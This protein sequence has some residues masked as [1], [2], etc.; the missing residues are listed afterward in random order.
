MGTR[1]RSAWGRGGGARQPGTQIRAAALSHYFEVAGRFG[2]DATALLR[3]VGLTRT[4]LADPSRPIPATAAAQLLELSAAAARCDSF[5]LRMAE[6]RQFSDFGPVSLLLAHQPTLRDALRTVIDY[7]HLLN[8]ALAMELEDL[9]QLAVVREE[10]AL[11]EARA[12][13]QST[14]LVV[15]VVLLIFRAVL[16]PQWR[17]RAVHFTHAAPAELAVHRRLFGCAPQFAADFN[18]LTCVAADL[19][20]PNPQADAEM[21]R[22]ARGFLDALPRRG[23]DALAQDVRRSIY[24]LLPLGRASAEQVASGLGLHVRTLQRRLGAR[25][26]AFADLLDEVRGELARRYIEGTTHSL[27][28]IAGLLGYSNPSA[29]TRW[30]GQRHGRP[31]S[32][33]RRGPALAE[34]EPSDASGAPDGSGVPRPHATPASRAG[35]RF[36]RP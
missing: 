13:R 1:T 21:A 34:H 28:R 23:V 4:L 18:G 22:Y 24:L 25:G 14:E 3:Q 31:P 33:L 16:G 5:G 6:A 2:L 10:L 27:G 32:F 17:P 36:R 26:L 12:V 35:A 9:G 30:Y 29:F 11:G 7:R 19:D 15:G 20:R 8:E